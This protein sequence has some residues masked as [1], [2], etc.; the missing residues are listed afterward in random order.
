MTTPCLNAEEELA[1]ARESTARRLDALARLVRQSTASL[2]HYDEAYSL[3]MK[4]AGD[5]RRLLDAK[6]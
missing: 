4:C 1:G 6:S 2:A 5:V 3:I